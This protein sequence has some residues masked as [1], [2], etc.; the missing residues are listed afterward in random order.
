M[1]RKLLMTL[2]LALPCAGAAA[3]TNLGVAEDFNA[4]VFGNMNTTNGGESEGPIAVGGNWTTATYNVNFKS[5]T[6][7][8]SAATVGSTTNI[9]AYVAGNVLVSGSTQIT[10]NAYVGGSVSGNALQFQ[11]GGTLNSGVNA[12]I[13]SSAPYISQSNFLASLNAQAI[14]TSDQNNLSIDL[15]TATQYGNFKVFSIPASQL[16]ANRTLSILNFSAADTLL[17]N[18]TG[19]NV[20]DFGLQITGGNYNQI[21]WNDSTATSF[22]I[23]NRIFEGSLLAPNAAITQSNV[24]EGN[25]VAASLTDSGGNELHFGSANQFSGTLLSQTSNPTPEPGTVALWAAGSVS[26]LMV[27]RRRSRTI[28][29]TSFRNRKA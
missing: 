25:V 23:D 22:N 27:R 15:N 18:I 20:S 19:G 24:I 12:S 3:Q 21:L 29:R 26:F 9:G 6:A 1:V 10:N 13:F 5:G 11:Q 17:I 28:R 7:G 16:S 14:N 4:F 2:A 8:Y